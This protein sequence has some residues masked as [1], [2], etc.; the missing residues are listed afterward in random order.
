ML[1][2]SR[3]TRF[4]P[5]AI[6]ACG[7]M[8]AGYASMI[9]TEPMP[10]TISGLSSGAHDDDREPPPRRRRRPG[11]TAES[12]PATP[13]R[14]LQP[15]RPRR[16]RVEKIYRTRNDWPTRRAAL[17]THRGAQRPYN[18]ELGP[19]THRCRSITCKTIVG[20]DEDGTALLYSENCDH[21]TCGIITTP[22][23]VRGA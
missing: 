3:G 19:G 11:S 16:E 13:R 17:A 10:I 21:F 5:N 14:A 15:A 12:Q 7:H 2:S 22:G 20:A 9:M 8:N 6:R 23:P 18:R 1:A 4:P